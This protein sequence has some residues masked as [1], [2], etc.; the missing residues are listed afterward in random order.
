M[1]TEVATMDMHSRLV[2]LQASTAKLR[3]QCFPAIRRT[4]MTK[5]KQLCTEQSSTGAATQDKSV[6]P[7]TVMPA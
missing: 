3:L 6:Y 2:L 7:P 1:L 4:Y 5:E